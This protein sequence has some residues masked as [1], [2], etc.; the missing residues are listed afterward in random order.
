[1][2]EIGKCVPTESAK[3]VSFIDMARSVNLIIR[4]ETFR[5]SNEPTFTKKDLRN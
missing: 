1:M 5:L 2:K 4:N 3:T